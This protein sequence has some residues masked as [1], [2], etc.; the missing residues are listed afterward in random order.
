MQR[1]KGGKA[2]VCRLP[3]ALSRLKTE[4]RIFDRWD[5]AANVEHSSGRRDLR[6]ST[7]EGGVQ[8]CSEVRGERPR[9]EV[10]E[11]RTSNQDR[12]CGLQFAFN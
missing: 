3:K 4:N 2:R 8:G 10:Q 7:Q 6:A 11:G 5:S 9:G 1:E 12:L